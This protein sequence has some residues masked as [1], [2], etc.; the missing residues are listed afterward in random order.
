[1]QTSADK[2]EPIQT[3]AAP[4]RPFQFGTRT[5][6]VAV[7]VVAIFAASINAAGWRGAVVATLAI[8]CAMGLYMGRTRYSMLW[9]ALWCVFAILV[10]DSLLLP[11]VNSSPSG[12]RHSRC[13]YNL[14]QIGAALRDYN[15]RIG[16]LPPVWTVDA[17]GKPLSSW[18]VA[19]LARLEHRA[20]YDQFHLEEAWNS[21][22]N[23]QLAAQQVSFFQC[24]S[25]FANTGPLHDT[26]YIAVIAPGSAWQPGKTIKLADITDNPAD[27][28][29]LV[30]IKNSGI[31]WAEPRDLDLNNLPSG[32]TPQNL[33]P[34]L[35]NHVKVFNALFAD[36]HVEAI[37]DTI[38]WPDFLALLTIAGGEQI[39]RSKW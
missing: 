34:S 38:S 21:P 15:G 4:A 31:G 23:M 25:D 30:E 26:S 10:V 24:P 39:D 29:L 17:A 18:R 32:I 33:I 36:G 19:I 11:S 35:V 8:S 20:L 27:T 3:A 1:M 5:I 2:R 28:I 37:P 14:N 9:A 6:L 13:G 16:N 22:H 12:S 7:L